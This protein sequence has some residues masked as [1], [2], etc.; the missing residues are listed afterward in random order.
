MNIVVEVLHSLL[1]LEIV[2]RRCQRARR[3]TTQYAQMR[4]CF[5][6]HLGGLQLPYLVDNSGQFRLRLLEVIVVF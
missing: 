5:R 4:Q 1:L 2:H 6:G 3:L